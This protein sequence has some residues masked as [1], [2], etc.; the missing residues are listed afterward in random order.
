MKE[1]NRL[2]TE[3]QNPLIYGIL[4][5]QGQDYPIRCNSW[6]SFMIKINEIMANFKIEFPFGEDN[7]LRMVV[8]K[9]KDTEVFK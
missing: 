1:M 5:S 2:Q 7:E 9:S 4:H 3:N 8:K 6:L